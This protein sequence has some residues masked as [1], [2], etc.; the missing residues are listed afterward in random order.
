[1]IR[2]QFVD[3]VIECD[4]IRQ[5]RQAPRTA[6]FRSPAQ[7]SRMMSKSFN[8]PAKLWPLGL[9]NRFASQLDHHA[10]SICCRVV[11]ELFETGVGGIDEVVR[12]A[13]SDGVAMS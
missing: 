8:A 11:E 5:P 10:H 3:E 9:F 2:V 4:D 12:L 1:M 13:S 7:Q 6:F